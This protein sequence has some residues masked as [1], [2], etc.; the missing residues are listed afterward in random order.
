MLGFLF[1][2]L[3]V[4][5]IASI[6]FILSEKK[7]NEKIE[8]KYTDLEKN[9]AETNYKL[10]FCG[11]GK[12]F[13]KIWITNLFLTICTLGIYYPW[14]RAKTKKYLYFSTYLNEY[15]FEFH[16]TGKQ[17][18]KGLLKFLLI[19]FLAFAGLMALVAI[20]P[21]FDYTKL[22]EQFLG[23]L[24]YIPYAPIL[25]LFIHGARKYGMAKTSHRGIR[26]GYRGIKKS[27]AL[28]MFRDAVITL[29]T[30][31]IYWPCIIN[32][33]RKYIYSNTRFGNV[34]FDFNGKGSSYWGI[35]VV[36][37]L[38]CIFT[39][40]IYYPWFKKELFN[41]FYE[42][43]FFSK[44]DKL[45]KIKSNATGGKFLEL[46]AVNWLIMLFTLGLGYPFAKIRSMRFIADN[47]ELYGNLDLDNVM[48][49]E[50]DYSDATGE[51]ETDMD[52]SAD[53]FDMDLF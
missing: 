19:M 39:F 7:E 23:L 43:I 6:F 48:Q 22:S 29:V 31:G 9:D 44:G 46:I 42:N 2:F 47:L 20:F 5:V 37:W 1:I 30:F 12:T 35:S 27:L 10:S 18:F 32:N 51:A 38:K 15:N 3:I 53:F 25:A 24:I 41:F 11:D 26:L 13:F 14:G 36:G 33:V 17:M 52:D 50:K 40:G 8:Q 16:G 21:E 45:A 28:Y 34:K 49:A 4:C